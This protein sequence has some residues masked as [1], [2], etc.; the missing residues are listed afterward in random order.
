MKC[1]SCSA[2]TK[3]WAEYYC[4]ECSHEW[5][6]DCVDPAELLELI[7][8]AENNEPLDLPPIGRAIYREGVIWTTVEALKGDSGP[9]KKMA[10]IKEVE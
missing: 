2:E 1:P 5:T 4:Q 7:E 8:K 9:L 6:G 10:G 3:P